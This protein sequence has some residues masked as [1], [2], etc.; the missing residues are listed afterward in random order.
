MTKSQ[1]VCYIRE[2]NPNESNLSAHIDIANFK[3]EYCLAFD[4]DGTT[5]FCMDEFKTVHVFERKANYRELESKGEL[6]IKE[7]SRQD[8][9]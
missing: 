5:F 2:I 1:G 9:K 6:N 7:F 8:I 3:A 4:T